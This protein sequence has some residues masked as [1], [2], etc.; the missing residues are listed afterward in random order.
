MSELRKKQKKEKIEKTKEEIQT[1]DTTME[2]L[3]KILKAGATLS[4]YAHTSTLSLRTH[5]P[6]KQIEDSSLESLIERI[7]AGSL[8][9]A[10]EETPEDLENSR[11]NH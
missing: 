3:K 6:H 4:G 8:V 7:L 1:E 11:L 10:Y 9:S 5:H 2:S